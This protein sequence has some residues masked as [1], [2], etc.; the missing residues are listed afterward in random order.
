MMWW[1]M[2]GIGAILLVILLWSAGSYAFL[3]LTYAHRSE[4][5]RRRF[6]DLSKEDRMPPRGS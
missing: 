1:I 6:D 5:E 2:G 3:K 4:E